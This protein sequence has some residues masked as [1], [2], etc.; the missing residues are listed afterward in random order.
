MP[1]TVSM[2]LAPGWRKMMRR[3]AGL[4]FDRPPFLMSST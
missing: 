1:L 4:P 2:M 3:M